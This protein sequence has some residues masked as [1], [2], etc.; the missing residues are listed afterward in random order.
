MSN[1]WGTGQA[2]PWAGPPLAAGLKREVGHDRVR[3]IAHQDGDVVRA[4]RLRSL[5]DD[6][7]LR[8]QPRPGQAK[9]R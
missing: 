1:S 5:R 8:A 7:G 3:A 4:E 6:R 2:P 9:L